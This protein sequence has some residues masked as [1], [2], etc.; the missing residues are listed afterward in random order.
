MAAPLGLDP[1]LALAIGGVLIVLGLAL[2]F[3]GRE[4][5]RMLMAIIGAALGG[6]LGF[7]LGAGISGGSS[8]LA[9]GLSLVGALIG[10]ILFGWLV[11]IALALVLGLLAA[12]VVLV[13]F[14]APSGAGLGGRPR[15]RAGGRVFTL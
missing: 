2:A 8:L 7:L 15:V 10:S 9:L 5:W 4:I 6:I 13:V 1:N 12:G 14:G 3:W 11:K